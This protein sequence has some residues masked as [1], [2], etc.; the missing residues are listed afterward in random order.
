MNFEDPLRQIVLPEKEGGLMTQ[1]F[2]RTIS[3]Q[4]TDEEVIK[5]LE[6][7]ARE[8]GLDITP[9]KSLSRV[10]Y[11][12]VFK[13]S[14]AATNLSNTTDVAKRLAMAKYLQFS[15]RIILNFLV[16]YD[17]DE[18]KQMDNYKELVKLLAKIIQNGH[19]VYAPA[20]DELA[21][22]LELVDTKLNEPLIYMAR[23]DLK[24]FYGDLAM[25]N[26]FYNKCWES[27]KH[28]Y[29][30]NSYSSLQR[31]FITSMHMD[32]SD[33]AEEIIKFFVDFMKDADKS[34]RVTSDQQS[35]NDVFLD[36]G[37]PLN[38]LYIFLNNLLVRMEE[39]KLKGSMLSKGVPVV[40][41]YV[42]KYCNE[43]QK[44]QTHILVDR[45]VWGARFRLK[46]TVN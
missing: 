44:L 34:I 31:Y 36:Y 3:E 21:R 26:D 42:N 13:I 7:L 4:L 6:P 46:C 15:I 14:E 24:F 23:G 5:N 18:V 11:E 1:I 30:L 25:A 27:D 41:R 33:R 16:R 32:N 22:E 20:S 28:C 40:L 38:T 37:Y 8:I 19:W 35:C 45:L 12:I 2:T 9:D 43:E 17:S 10:I 29:T 39:N